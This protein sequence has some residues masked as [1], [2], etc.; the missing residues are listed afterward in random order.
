MSAA[1]APA[2]GPPTGGAGATGGET[3]WLEMGPTAVVTGGAPDPGGVTLGVTTETAKAVVWVAAAAAAGAAGTGELVLTTE[4]ADGPPVG[5]L[6]FVRACGVVAP[7]PA[8][9]SPMLRPRLEATGAPS[10]MTATKEPTATAPLSA[11][12]ADV[13]LR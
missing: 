5:K 4:V 13:S 12:I 1:C 9:G 8:D 3:T 2:L 11:L 7:W 10:S 6:G